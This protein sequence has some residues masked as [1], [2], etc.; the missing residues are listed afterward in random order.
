MWSWVSMGPETKNDCA[1]EAQQQFTGL[2]WY[3]STISGD[4]TQQSEGNE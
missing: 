1:G 4:S 3:E 2:E